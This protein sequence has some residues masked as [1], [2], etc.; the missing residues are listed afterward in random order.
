M[1]YRKDGRTYRL[2]TAKQDTTGCE[3]CEIRCP[4]YET[5]ELR[6]CAV[7]EK[8]G[9]RSKVYYWSETLWSKIRNWRR[10]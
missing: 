9:L 10:K 3:M 5:S 2:V 8:G 4:V 7:D 6:I 1:K